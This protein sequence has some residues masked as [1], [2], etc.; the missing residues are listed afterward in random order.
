MERPP[1]F[2]A[3]GVVLINKPIGHTSFDVVA[4]VRRKLGLKR[5]GHAGTLDPMATGVLV[6]AFDWSTRLV[7][8]LT[9]DSKTYR[10]VARLGA[11]TDTDDA[12]GV[13]V[14]ERDVP[15]IGEATLRRLETSFSG[16]IKQRPPAYSAIHID[17]VRAHKLARRGVEVAIPER[18]VS[19]DM[20]RLTLL[21]AN[22]LA[23]EMTASAGTYVR[24]LARD[25]GEELG[26][27]AHL[28][29]LERSASGSFLLENCI[30]LEEFVTHEAPLTGR[31]ALVP[32]QATAAMATVELSP[33]EF[34]EVGFGR[35]IALP[36]GHAPAEVWRLGWQG[37]LA[38]LAR[39]RVYEQGQML[40]PFRVVPSRSGLAEEPT[41][42]EGGAPP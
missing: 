13:A 1:G 28:I 18:D 9:A 15:H 10:A 12:D 3:G 31:W 7:E 6:V 14:L 30:D 26:C 41:A 11:V 32:W 19:I 42:D 5:V 20:L 25:I 35:P 16:A 29:A 2:E 8:Y 39:R 17:G 27:G 21:D 34:R 23:I 36:V 40:H 22:T 33:E 37:V 24:S 4:R 38:G